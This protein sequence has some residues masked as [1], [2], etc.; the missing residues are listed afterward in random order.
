MSE[1]PFTLEKPDRDHT[2]F[3]SCP[4]GEKFRELREALLLAVIAKKYYPVLE[5]CLFSPSTPTP[6][7]LTDYI[8]KAK[9]SVHECTQCNNDTP[10]HEERFNLPIELGM[11]LLEKRRRDRERTALLEKLHKEPEK[12]AL[13]EKQCRELIGDDRGML[14]H[15]IF[16]LI[17]EEHPYIPFLQSLQVND[18][19]TYPSASQAE[20]MK[21]IFD[22]LPSQTTSVDMGKPDFNEVEK[23]W[24]KFKKSK[25]IRLDDK[26][27]NIEEVRK[28]LISVCMNAALWKPKISPVDDEIS[29]RSGRH[30]DIGLVIALKEEFKV[31]FS[32][33]E[34]THKERDSETNEHYYFFEKPGKEKNYRCVVVFIG[35]MG[36]KD[37]GIAT[38]RLLNKYAPAAVINIGLAGSLD[39]D[40]LIGDIVI[41]DQIDEYLDNSKA[42]V[43][44]DKD[45]FEFKLSGKVYRGTEEYIQRT[46]NLETWH[47][48]EYGK[49][50]ESCKKRRDELP[51]EAFQTQDDKAL[52]NRE[53]VTFHKGHIASGFTVGSSEHYAKWLKEERDRK[54]LALEMEAAGVMG[55]AQSRKTNTLIIKAISDFSDE[56][57]K[58]ADK[59]DKGALRRYAMQNSI[60]LLWI[61][62]ELGFFENIEHLERTT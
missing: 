21:Y 35:D 13:L 1:I 25:R 52:V 3:I 10:E 50:Q 12:M 44:K 40:V 33:I 41:A 8:L 61:M 39:K 24:K 46:D 37:A 48:E 29:N 53:Q 20:A 45:G 23:I 5:Q 59:I 55:A 31:L 38:E 58:A 62:M 57:K 36:S 7:Y 30:V 22:W 4:C 27:S 18:R 43:S 49:W 60:D 14:D 9:Y 6:A 11:A 42:V 26:G 16:I 51:E 47:E 15:K 17:E 56:H 54:Y 34:C 28:H 2:V 32:E 19:G